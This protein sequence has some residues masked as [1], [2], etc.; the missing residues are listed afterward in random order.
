M[1]STTRE[2]NKTEEPEPCL[3]QSLCILKK[4]VHDWQHLPNIENKTPE[5]QNGKHNNGN[6]ENQPKQRTNEQTGHLHNILKTNNI[7][8]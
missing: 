3:V 5:A 7:Y 4:S 8:T 2:Q 6:K 1:G